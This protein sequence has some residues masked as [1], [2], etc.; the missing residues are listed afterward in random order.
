MAKTPPTLSI[1]VMSPS[2]TL[3]QGHA[4]AIS[5]VN[6]LGRFDVLPRHANFISL[7]HNEVVILPLEGQ[8]QRFPLQQGVMYVKDQTVLVFVGVETQAAL[9]SL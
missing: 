9:A 3:Y 5:S 8:K 7:I 1:T 6:E 2:G 4:T